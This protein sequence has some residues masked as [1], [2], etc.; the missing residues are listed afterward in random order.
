MIPKPFILGQ[1][2]RRPPVKFKKW[3]NHHGYYGVFFIAF[4]VFNLIMGWNNLE[5]LFPLWYACTG[6]GVF[7]LVDDIWEHKISADTPC[8]IIWEIIRTKL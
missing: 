6:V 4:G 2:L 5:V 1:S 3:G 8:R 7:M